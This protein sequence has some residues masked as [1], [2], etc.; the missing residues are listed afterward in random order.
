MPN[1]NEQQVRFRDLSWKELVQKAWGK[2]WNKPEKAYEFSGGREF[3]STDRTE[4]G[5]YKRPA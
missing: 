1:D 2:D 3:E 4:S 5:I